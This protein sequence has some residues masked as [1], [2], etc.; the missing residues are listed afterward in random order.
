M[1]ESNAKLL[2]S[3][4]YITQNNNSRMIIILIKLKLIEGITDSGVQC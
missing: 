3:A 2:C 4:V 1:K